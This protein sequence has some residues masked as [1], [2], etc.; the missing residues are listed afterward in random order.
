MPRLNFTKNLIKL[1]E[2]GTKRQAIR[3]ER[4]TSMQ[5]G[6]KLYFFTG[7]G[8]KKC[9]RLNLSNIPNTSHL[10]DK[11]G[12]YYVTINQIDDIEM[13]IYEDKNPEVIV[14]G[15]LLDMF[16]VYN[17]AYAEGFIVDYHIKNYFWKTINKFT[18]HYLEHY[19]N[20]FKGYIIHW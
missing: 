8:T 5:Y 10:K 6:D 15:E 12:Y 9:K 13:Y 4:R 2:S 3:T 19:G 11:N 1:I 7:S 14:N 18:E 20:Y 16:G 17:I